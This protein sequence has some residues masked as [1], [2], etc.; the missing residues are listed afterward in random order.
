MPVHIRPVMTCAMSSGIVTAA[1]P[2]AA[3]DCRVG[4]V[5]HYR[6]PFARLMIIAYISVSV[7]LCVSLSKDTGPFQTRKLSLSIRGVA[8]NAI[9]F[10][11]LHSRPLSCFPFPA[12]YQ[13]P[14][15]L[16]AKPQSLLS[17]CNQFVPAFSCFSVANLL[18]S[19]RR[20]GEKNGVT[21]I[22]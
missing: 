22:C 6:C 20:K 12:S 5:A 2:G 13:Q 15:I 18:P 21:A 19:G 7:C 14:P 8:I 10:P 1:S 16:L 3:H 11:L 9:R 17:Y 4:H